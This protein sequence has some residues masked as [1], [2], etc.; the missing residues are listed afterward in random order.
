MAI[1]DITETWIVPSEDSAQQT[2]QLSY[3][4]HVPAPNYPQR[5]FL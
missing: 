3:A 5:L 1:D 4:D 2:Y